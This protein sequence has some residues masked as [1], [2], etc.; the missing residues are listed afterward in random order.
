MRQQPN[1][2][3]KDGMNIQMPRVAEDAWLKLSDSVSNFAGQ[4]ENSAGARPRNFTQH[5]RT[6]RRAE[7]RTRNPCRRR[8]TSE[9]FHHK[10]LARGGHLKVTLKAPQL[11]MIRFSRFSGAKQSQASQDFCAFLFMRHANA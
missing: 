10:S 5:A 11:E 8:K 3:S 6:Q 2:A 4:K 7:S 9:R 1:T